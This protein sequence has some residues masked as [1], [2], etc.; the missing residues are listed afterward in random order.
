MTAY[1]NLETKNVID[2][3]LSDRF[4]EYVPGEM[5]FATIVDLSGHAAWFV[6]QNIHRP[7]PFIDVAEIMARSTFKSK[8]A[9]GYTVDEY[10]MAAA[11]LNGLALDIGR[12]MQK[13][14]GRNKRK[15]CTQLAADAF[16]AKTADLLP[17]SV[18]ELYFNIAAKKKKSYGK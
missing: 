18:A 8:I 10:I 4:N 15:L 12:D 13:E 1:G 16:K 9:N 7:T 6:P 11:Y 2:L 14:L 17:I 5:T 3:L